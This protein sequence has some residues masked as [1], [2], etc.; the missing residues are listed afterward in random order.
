VKIDSVGNITE[1][2]PDYKNTRTLVLSRK[3][4]TS[5]VEGTCQKMI[6][7]R[8]QA[9]DDPGFTHPVDLYEITEPPQACYQLVTVKP[10][11]TYKYYRYLSPKR[12]TCN[13]AELE[14]YEAGSDNKQ[15]GKVIGGYIEKFDSTLLVPYYIRKPKPRENSSFQMQANWTPTSQLAA[16]A[17]YLN[18]IIEKYGLQPKQL[19]EK[20]V[21][22]DTKPLPDTCYV[23][24]FDG[25]PLTFFCR[26]NMEYSWVG[27]EF[28]QPKHISRVAFLPRN[29]DNGVMAGQ[30]YELFF[31]DNKWIS[32]GR[33]TAS[34]KTYRLHYKNAPS[35]ALF[36]LRNLTKGKEERIFTYEGGKQVWW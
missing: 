18:A 21:A 36:L 23:N 7:A 13:L 3:Y 10:A 33:Q 16:E 28:S 25:D 12:V 30:L 35:N 2:R 14:F 19:T 32:L 27:M 8:L 34:N 20:A 11:R 17:A 5:L 6:G 15:V 4:Q 24:A 29:D 1:L 9:S 26:Y 31:W 22:K